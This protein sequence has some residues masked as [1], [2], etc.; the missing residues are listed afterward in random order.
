MFLFQNWLLAL[1][2]IYFTKQSKKNVTNMVPIN[3]SWK[4]A[5]LLQR[6]SR[7]E[8]IPKSI[9]FKLIKFSFIVNFLFQILYISMRIYLLPT[10]SLIF[11]SIPVQCHRDF[12]KL[13]LAPVH[14]LL[15][16]WKE[17]K[18]K[19]SL[20]VN[21]VIKLAR[22][23]ERRHSKCWD[24]K[25]ICKYFDEAMLALKCLLLRGMKSH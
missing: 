13:S 10:I 12:H 15:E 9:E 18:M 21:V 11:A 17:I 2:K 16:Y 5:L 3:Y 19:L 25:L 22:Q 8:I 4:S 7:L 1:L 23:T 6:K 24:A 20:G 14:R